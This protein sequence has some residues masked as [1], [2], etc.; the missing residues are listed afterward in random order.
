MSGFDPISYLESVKKER[1]K[2]E[3][4]FDPITYLENKITNRPPEEEPSYL[5]KISGSLF[6]GTD[7]YSKQLAKEATPLNPGITMDY[8]R[9]REDATAA[10]DALPLGVRMG[11]GIA[12]SPMFLPTSIVLSEAAGLGA[13]GIVSIVKEKLNLDPEEDSLPEFVDKLKEKGFGDKEVQEQVLAKMEDSAKNIAWDGAF[14]GLFAAGSM[15]ASTA[16][17]NAKIIK[18]A[19]KT[20]KDDSLS[21]MFNKVDSY[22]EDS[23]NIPDGMIRP[24]NEIA[25]RA[26]RT[27]TPATASGAG[28]SGMI[29]SLAIAPQTKKTVVQQQTEIRD[30]FNNRVLKEINT[31]GKIKPKHII[32]Q[33]IEDQFKEVGSKRLGAF[34]PPKKELLTGITIGDKMKDSV[35]SFESSRSNK[36]SSL[37]SQADMNIPGSARIEGTNFMEAIDDLTK[38]VPVLSKSGLKEGLKG[39]KS[40]TEI[41]DPLSEKVIGHLKDTDSKLGISEWDE[42]RKQI[43]KRAW[44]GPDGTDSKQLKMLGAAMRADEKV[45]VDK[46][47]SKGELSENAYNK[48]IKARSLWADTDK[49][50]ELARSIVSSGDGY[51]IF[52]QANKIDKT[53][54]IEFKSLLDETGE[55]LFADFRKENLHKLATDPKTEEISLPV[56][57]KNYE[58]MKDSGVAEVM[59]GD[60]PALHKELNTM[61][62]EFKKINGLQSLEKVGRDDPSKALNK[63]S[64]VDLGKFKSILSK[65]NPELLNDSTAF[66]LKSLGS[67]PAGKFDGLTFANKI[68]VLEQNGLAKEL[69][70][71]NVW[72]KVKDIAELVNDNRVS[73]VA[74]GKEL[75]AQGSQMYNMVRVGFG[76]AGGA[77]GGAGGALGGLAASE[78]IIQGAPRLFSKLYSNPVYLRWAN[79]VI[80]TRKITERTEELML[81][82]LIGMAEADEDLKY[83]L[84]E[85]FDL[86]EKV[87]SHIDLRRGQQEAQKPYSNGKV[88][89]ADDRR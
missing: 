70:P 17:N 83:N 4:K 26:A 65:T 6:P 64:K 86:G 3:K 82:R 9:A 80:K 40:K 59:F 14:G 15:I 61:L 55:G 68:G 19:Y 33:E 46:L 42:L 57:I 7:N 79:S 87:Q 44:N 29:S 34:I 35:K 12:T 8:E 84:L 41:L 66:I 18:Q 32:A 11:V 50:M 85:L 48:I 88:Q 54:L 5:D 24:A 47:F 63:L 22:F 16:I 20:R 89:F 60:S 77:A 51:T 81:G 13:E 74:A 49:K 56:F 36:I 10:L 78:A 76:F 21:T 38:N 73:Y 69:M 37:Y 39:Y 45:F 2:E 53:K 27:G 58:N 71:E 25:E 43:S 52:N 30:Y 28:K 31:I 62:G 75:E 72:S 23:A 67:N 1:D